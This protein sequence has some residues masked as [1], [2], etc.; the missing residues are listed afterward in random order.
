MNLSLRMV[1]YTLAAVTLLA[2]CANPAGTSK[3]V[4]AASAVVNVKIVAFNDFH[5]NLQPPRISIPAPAG[6]SAVVA[7]PA[8]GAA[9]L[10][11]AIQ[12][13][14]AQNPN[15]VVLSAG[16]MIG[17]TP[18][19]SAMFLDEPTIEVANA[20]RIDFNAVGN[21]EFDKGRAELLRMQ[22]GG[23]EKH[24]VRQPCLVSPAFAGANFGFLAA[25]VLQADGST[26]FPAT[27]LREFSGPGYSVKVGFIGMTL[28]GTPGIVTPAGIAGLTFADE[29]AT[30][31]ALI[32]QLRAQGADAIVLIVHE[33]GVTTGGFN[34]KS[35][36][37]LVGDIL[38]ILEK[39][40]PGVD[41]VVSGHTHRA[42]ICD[43]SKINP[44]KP[45]LLTSAGQYGT[46]LSDINLAID[47]VRRQVVSKSANNVIVQGEGFMNSAGETIVVSS[48]YPS[49]GKDPVVEK[50]VNT[51][52]AAAAPLAQRVVGILAGPITR[53]Q[54]VS[55]ESPLGNL[56]ADAQLAATSSPER[57]GAQIAFMNPGGVRADLI[58]P[59][60]GGAVTYGQIFSSQ[61][62]GNSLVVKTFS[63]AQIKALLEQQF[64]NPD[65]PRLLYPSNGLSYSYNLALAEGSRISELKL[66]AVA[67]ADSASYRVTMNSFL[68]T[69]GDGFSIFSQ[70]RQALGGALDVDALESYLQARP[71]IEAPPATRVTKL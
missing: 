69:G 13:L 53:A 57:G 23:C 45:F 9:Y 54:S 28:K 62:F 41:L 14:K 68:A 2:G 27:G 49:F 10:S 34:D 26:L 52:A 44:A 37:G 3:P 59:P 19:V 31:N 39:L 20:I 8:G 64:R 22:Y 58:V 67:I 42:Y 40:D 24:T 66:N 36:P 33:G 48:L 29:A 43:Y 38:P 71:M 17:A 32:P 25:N 63:G 6:G 61:P 30:A 46:L 35:C 70:G 21:H 60:T 4:V 65:S 50:L 55:R 16:D 18:L 7:V 12:A 51:Y 56:I 5:G 1:V 15:H 47:P 11:S